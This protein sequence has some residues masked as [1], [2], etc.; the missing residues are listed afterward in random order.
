MPKVRK[1]ESDIQHYYYAQRLHV[2]KTFSMYSNYM[3]SFDCMYSA[4][5]TKTG[6]CTI[7]RYRGRGG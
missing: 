1:L 2:L 7:H 6:T 4:M 3:Y 5:E